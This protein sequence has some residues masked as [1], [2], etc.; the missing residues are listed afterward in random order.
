MIPIPWLKVNAF[1]EPPGRG[2]TAVVCLLD[3]ERERAWMQSAATEWGVAGTAFVRPLAD[4]FSLKFFTPAVEVSLSG[5]TTLAAAH[6]LWTEGVLREQ[7]AIRFHTRSG[8]LTCVRKGRQIE[9]ELPADPPREVQAPVELLEGLGVEFEFVGQTEFDMLVRV[10]SE[11]AVRSLLPNFAWL[12]KLATRGVIV[13]SE[14]A[15]PGFDFV[16]RFFAPAAGLDE[17]HVTGSAHCSL[18]P[19][20]SERLGKQEMTAFQASARGGVL[21]VRVD[22]ERVYLAGEAETVGRGELEDP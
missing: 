13:T 15:A 10:G 11:Q 16:S 18:G 4:G 3:E 6:T 2:N 5:H 21:R 22:G 14:S 20:W 8:I 1:T 17:D 7:E 12:R 9:L 19:Y